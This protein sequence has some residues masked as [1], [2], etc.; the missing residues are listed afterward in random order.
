MERT[1]MSE[2]H[3]VIE[4]FADGERVDVTTLRAA[5]AEPAGRDHLIDVLALRGLVAGSHA[6]GLHGAPAVP[7]AAP[8]ARRLGVRRWSAAAA[9]L[10]VAAGAYVAGLR[11]GE[12]D[13]RGQRP[14][15]SA[16]SEVISTVAPP[17]SAPTPTRV[18]RL[19]PGVDWNER[20]G[21]D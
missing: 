11:Q 18:F 9:V 3:D 6:F 16:T 21:G 10:L 1:T 4:A 13:L 5:L 20:R 2:W 17:V 12:N 7:A 15:R 8:P 14:P 19:E